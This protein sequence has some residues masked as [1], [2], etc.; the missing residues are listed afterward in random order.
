MI[1]AYGLNGFTDH[2]LPDALEVLA[3]L[4]YRGVALTL[5]HHHLDP[6]APD[7][8]ARVAGAADLLRQH[9]LSVVVETGA[10]FLLDPRRKHHPTLVCAA[11]REVR[12][13]LL[14]RAIALAPDLGARI[15]HLWSG[16]LPP[17]TPRE[18]GWDRLVRGMDPVVAAA[19]RAGVTLAFE[20]EPG[21]FLDRAAGVGELLRRMG[22]PE[23]LRMTLDL[24]HLI[25]NEEDPVSLVR[26]VGAD[27]VHVQV[28]DMLPGVHEHLPLGEGEVDLPPLLRALA[29]AQYRG[30]LSIELGRD[31]HRAPALAAD[32]ITALRAAAATAAVPL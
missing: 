14:V 28:D 1:P 12:V 23:A 27:V 17:D 13:D 25:C 30:Q 16:I 6:Y 10:R 4:G 2:R 11:D 7:L 26:E 9:D 22:R 21:M 20:P 19:E 15:V 18:V 8:A 32:S 31:S 3:D 5:D 24:G 29:D